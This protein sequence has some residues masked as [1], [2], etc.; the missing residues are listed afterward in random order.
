MGFFLCCCFWWRCRTIMGRMW[1]KGDMWRAKSWDYVIPYFIYN[2]LWKGI[3]FFFSNS[4]FFCVVFAIAKT[5]NKNINIFLE[6]L[7]NREVVSAFL[8]YFPI[9]LHVDGQQ[10]WWFHVVFIFWIPIVPSFVYLTLLIMIFLRLTAFN[11][12]SFRGSLRRRMLL[13]S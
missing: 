6:F 4:F 3:G 5:R 11:S 10:R 7:E 12:I 13:L 2:F 8:I 1:A 9:G